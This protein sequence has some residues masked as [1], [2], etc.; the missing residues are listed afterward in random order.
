VLPS[1]TVVR[2]RSVEKVYSTATGEVHALHDISAS[3]ASGTLTVIA[4]PSGSGKS[5]LLRILACLDRPE[6]G[7]VDMDGVDLTRLSNR[8][9]RKF[10][11]TVIGYVFQS[12]DHNLLPYL[13]AGEHL[14]LA[15]RLRGRGTAADVSRLLDGLGL[16]DRRDHRPVQLSGGEQQRLAFAT[17]VIGGPRL[18]VADEPTAELDSDAARHLID[19][20]AGLRSEGTTLVVSSHDPAVVVAADHVISLAHG[21]LVS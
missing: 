21:A 5:S 2:C 10:R 4:G 9:R 7:S 8:Q 12:P 17:A 14:E 19:L 18:V 16:G 1:D 15:A 11:R 20:V 13:S 3:V 6:S